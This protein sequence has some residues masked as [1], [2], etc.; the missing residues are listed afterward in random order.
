M[1]GSNWLYLYQAAWEGSPAL[2][3]DATWSYSLPPVPGFHAKDQ[4]DGLEGSS[5]GLQQVPC[6]DGQ[7]AGLVGR[8]KASVLCGNAGSVKPCSL[9]ALQHELG[10]I[11]LPAG[12]RVPCPP[13]VYEHT[14]FLSYL[15]LR[16]D[17]E[18]WG[19]GRRGAMT[20]PCSA[21]GSL[22]SLTSGYRL[23]GCNSASRGTFGWSCLS[24]LTQQ[25]CPMR[26]WW[27][28]PVLL[29]TT[30][31]SLCGL[32]CQAGTMTSSVSMSP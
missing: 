25:L 6:L 22:P 13:N 20:P 18:H 24:G 4:A 26:V 28:A 3:Q 16:T 30:L 15:L 19:D 27:R 7:E 32:L 31:G 11:S 10:S 5:S 8:Q 2:C 23:H 17:A 29:R 21:I 9:G 12:R 14:C 1:L